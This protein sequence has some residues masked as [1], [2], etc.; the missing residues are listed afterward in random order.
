V[1]QLLGASARKK[2]FLSCFPQNGHLVWAPTAS[3]VR[4]WRL[5]LLFPSR[6]VKFFTIYEGEN[7][8]DGYVFRVIVYEVEVKI[9]KPVLGIYFGGVSFF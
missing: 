2:I 1:G 4:Q 7:S 3:K 6:L 9:F 5:Y 8:E